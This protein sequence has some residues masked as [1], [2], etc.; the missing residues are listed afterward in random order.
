MHVGIGDMQKYLLLAI[1]TFGPLLW[2]GAQAISAPGRRRAFLTG[3]SVAAVST[4]PLYVVSEDWGRWLH[5]TGVLVFVTVLACKDLNVHLPAR[6]PALAVPFFG[7]IAIFAFSW[8][9][10]HWIHSPLPILRP[11]AEHVV[12]LVKAHVLHAGTQ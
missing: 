12:V 2:Y 10:P 11:S 9:L 4:A 5:V 1:L 3:I 6:R 7:A 8:Q